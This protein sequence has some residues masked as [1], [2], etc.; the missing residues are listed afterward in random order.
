MDFIGHVNHATYLQILEQVRWDLITERNYGID[1]IKK[2]G[3]SPIVLEV[4]IKYRKEL[5]LRDVVTIK[6]ETQLSKSKT[7]YIQQIMYKDDGEVACSAKIKFGLFDMNLRA[8]VD[9]DE[10]WKFAIGV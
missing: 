1:H 8:L 3:I 4:N 6:T 5:L 7:H 9:A 2:M 10:E